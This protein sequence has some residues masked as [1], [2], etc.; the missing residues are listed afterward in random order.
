MNKRTNNKLIYLI[1]FLLGFSCAIGEQI[2]V[3]FSLA[4]KMFVIIGFVVIL[5]F[6]FF[7]KKT[8]TFMNNK[9]LAF[10]YLTFLIFQ[11]IL[12]LNVIVNKNN[13]TFLSVID[14]LKVP[15][16][17][18]ICFCLVGLFE[19]NKKL[20]VSFLCGF[21]LSYLIFLPM[22]QKGEYLNIYRYFGTYTNP[23]TFAIDCY[24]MLFALLFFLVKS[25]HKLFFMLLLIV[26]LVMQLLTGSRGSLLSLIIGLLFFLMGIKNRKIKIAFISAGVLVLL[27]FV[28]QPGETNLLNRLF[29]KES[30]E[31]NVRLEIWGS[32]LTNMDKYFWFGMDLN[33]H[34]MIHH[35]TPHN[36][37]L[38]SFVRYGIFG[39]VLYM[40]II[41]YVLVKNVK[42]LFNK[43]NY[44][45]SS[46]V[47]ACLFITFLFSC[48]TIEL[49][50][51]RTSY[52]I[53]SLCTVNA[54]QK[55]SV[56][57]SEVTQYVKNKNV[58]SLA[59]QRQNGFENCH[60]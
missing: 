24:F 17:L 29:S 6:I 50:E 21:V 12:S 58:S 7:V 42:V 13:N 45:N 37:Y 22:C 16:F 8:D 19:K 26:P 51:I 20:I 23:N 47:L 59:F 36:N 25:K 38:G 10:L 3:Y 49:V 40:S 54:L 48:L 60:L 11:I 28:F 2:N 30:Y 31:D 33:N 39:F 55:N 5:Y 1:T 27:F 15:L 52:I 43:N 41:V 18:A 9:A 56:K 53:M 32:Y 57:K 46:K 4:S 14:N 44:D 35:W 34:E